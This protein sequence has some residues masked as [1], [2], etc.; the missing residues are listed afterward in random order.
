[1]KR[2]SKYGRKYFP[3][4]LLINHLYPEY[5]KNFDNSIIEVQ[6]LQ[7]KIRQQSCVDNSPMTMYIK[8]LKDSKQHQP[9]GN[10]NKKQNEMLLHSNKDGYNS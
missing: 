4:I 2:E 7:L 6:I 3:I 5:I 10:A 1:M 8:H 9:C